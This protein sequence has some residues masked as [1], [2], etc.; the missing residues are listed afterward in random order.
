MSHELDHRLAEIGENIKLLS[1]RQNQQYTDLMIALNEL[2][3]L[4]ETASALPDD[5]ELYDDAREFV[6][7]LASVTVTI[8]QRRLGIGYSRAAK[9]IDLLE[10]EGV[11]SPRDGTRPRVVLRD[12]P[13]V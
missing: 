13:F 10:A 3:L 9:I 1:E 5:D 11:I 8:L 4:V 12:E 7:E 2:K 6:R